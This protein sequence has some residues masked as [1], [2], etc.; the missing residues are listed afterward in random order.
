[1]S[2]A[3]GVL[4]GRSARGALRAL[5]P[6]ASCERAR[7]P[8]TRARDR[9]LQLRN[10][11]QRDTP[12][13]ICHIAQLANSWQ[14][15]LCERAACEHGL[16]AGNLGC[17]HEAARGVQRARA[18]AARTRRTAQPAL[19]L[20]FAKFGSAC[21][22]RRRASRRRRAAWRS[23]NCVAWCAP[24]LPC[25]TTIRAARTWRTARN[26]QRSVLPVPM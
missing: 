5:S 24:R 18:A 12:I 13:K 15:R 3:S 19:R 20:A 22:S 7:A 17:A 16:H 21:S 4:C 25:A 6:R 14:A 11:A 10:G 23:R 1:M 2:C 26:C 8:R 9:Q